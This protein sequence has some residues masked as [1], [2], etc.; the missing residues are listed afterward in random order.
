MGN[1]DKSIDNDDIN[2]KTIENY[3]TNL[4]G[5]ENLFNIIQYKY[6]KFKG[7]KQI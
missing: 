3:S 5:P 7:N 4:Q 2:D 6:M 1:E